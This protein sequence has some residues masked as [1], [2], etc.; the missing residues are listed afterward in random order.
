METATRHCGISKEIDERHCDIINKIDKR[1]CVIIKEKDIRHFVQ[2]QIQSMLHTR[3]ISRGGYIVRTAIVR[4]R[5][6]WVLYEVW[7]GL[8]DGS[9]HYISTVVELYLR[10]P[11]HTTPVLEVTS[12]RTVLCWIKVKR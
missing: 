9:Y 11:S 8:T 4:I 1:Y 2:N 7:F 10:T 6:Y 3:I 5:V 12:L